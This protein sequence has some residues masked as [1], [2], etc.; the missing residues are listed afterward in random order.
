MTAPS[1]LAISS[2][3]R[4]EDPRLLKGQGTYLDDI[5]LPGMLHLAVLRSPHAHAGI[6]GLRVDAARALPGVAAVVTAV[7]VEGF[8]EFPVLFQPPGQRQTGYPILPRGKVIYAGEPIAIVAADNRYVAEDAV[9][10]IEVDFAPLPAVV[11]VDEAMVDGAPR[12]HEAWPDNMVAWREI[13]RGDPDAAFADAHTVVEATFDIP[14]QCCSPLEG[15]GVLARYDA[16]TGELIMWVSSQ[17]PHQYRTILAEM[18]H[19]EEHRLR[20]IV[21]DVGGGFGCKLHYYPEEVVACI[22]AMRL[23]RPIKWIEDRREHLLSTVHAREQRVRA[24]AAFDREGCLVGLQAHVRGDAGAHLHT[25]G[26][27][28]VFVT[29]LLLPGPYAVRHY[30]ARVEVVVTNKTPF[31][32]YRG[33]GMQQSAFLIE[34]LMDMG[35]QRLGLDPAEI[36][37]R[38]LLAP[39]VFPYRSAGG[40]LYD[41]GNYPEAMRRALA[42]ADYPALRAKQAEMRAAGRLVGIGIGVY[43]EFTGMGPSHLMGAI[44]NRQGGYETVIVRLDATGRVTLL[45]GIIE[46]GQGIRASLAGITAKVLSIPLDHVRVVLGDTDLTPYSSYGTADSRGSVVAGTAAIEACRLLRSKILRMGAHMLEAR[47]EDVELVDGRCVVRGTPDRAVT[48][49]QVGREAYRGQSIPDRTDPGMEAQY[50]YH[51]DNWAFPYGVHIAM[52]E[53]DRG[54]GA[55]GF[56]GYWIVHDCG[57]LISPMLV[58][59]QIHGGLAQ[60]IGGS[61]F[62][63][64]IYDKDGQLLSSTLMDYLLPSA[65]EMPTPVVGHM[66]TPSPDSPAGIK[67]MAEGGTI[68]APGAVVNAVADALSALDPSLGPALGFYP[69]GPS[70]ILGMIRRRTGPRES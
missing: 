8:G 18:L 5:R 26:A 60:G 47:E 22:L 19:L 25:K 32:A 29:G 28:P 7:D 21:P 2:L 24:R 20:L 63:E 16:P 44:G 36:R 70:R 33:F 68:G 40:F 41:S 52:V 43:L 62:E 48:I 37:M 61:L 64:L 53:V 67:G 14:R 23:R 42:L 10:L 27:A 35:A 51:P 15:R 65:S 6:R 39:D 59:G 31:G 46:I 56:L 30:H 69:L 45:S 17:A 13:R 58:E 1:S 57:K 55:V 49:A 9:E 11:D 50:T 3:R 4:Q 54:T 38:N 66:E 12:L 34:R